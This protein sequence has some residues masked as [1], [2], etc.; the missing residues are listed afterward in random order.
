MRPSEDVKRL[1]ENVPINT[2]VQRDD[3]ILDDV[4]NTFEQSQNA[5]SASSQPSIWRIIMKSRV[6]KFAA[7]IIVIGVVLSFFVSERAPFPS[8]GKRASWC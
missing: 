4:L 6:S 2:N 8:G 1:I 5:Q 3:E 7:A